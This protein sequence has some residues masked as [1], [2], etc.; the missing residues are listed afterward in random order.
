MMV[1]DLTIVQFVMQNSREKIIWK[2]IYKQFM[3]IVMN[4]VN[5]NRLDL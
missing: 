1:L 2:L 4:Q 5:L 3:D